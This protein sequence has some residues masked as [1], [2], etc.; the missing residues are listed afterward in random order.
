MQAA[1]LLSCSKPRSASWVNQVLEGEG[2]LGKIFVS[3]V[4]AFVFGLQGEGGRGEHII[5]CRR[6]EAKK[7]IGRE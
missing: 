3:D 7:E 1:I 6:K 5:F 4:L 2:G